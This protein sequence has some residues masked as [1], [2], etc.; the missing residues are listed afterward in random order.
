MALRI[1]SGEIV[2]SAMGGPLPC[3]SC[4]RCGRGAGSG[5]GGSAAETPSGG[6]QS[7]GDA[8]VDDLVADPDYQAAEHAGVHGHLEGD[9]DERSEEHTSELQSHSDIV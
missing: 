3:G 8:A 1:S 6:F 7:V 9:G 5:L 2:S 4:L